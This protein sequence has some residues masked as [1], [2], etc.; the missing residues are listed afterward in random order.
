MQKA[1]VAI[2]DSRFYQHGGVDPK[3]LLRAFLINKI[4]GRI[5]QG[6]STLTQQY[7][8]NVL[9]ES[10]SAQDN[11]Q[12]V[13]DAQEKS[14]G[15]KL[16]E[17]RYAVSLEKE[18]SKDEILNR[19]L[20]IAFF[21]GGQV[22]G[23][24]AAARHYFNV[25]AKKLSL[26]QA[27]MLAG[28]VQNPAAWSPT[29]HPAAALVRRDV[30][31]AR[32]LQ[33]KVIDQAT[34]DA[35][36]KAKLGVKITKA[37]NGCANAGYNA[38]YC[39]YVDL[40]ITQ[41]KSFSSVGATQ[42]ER[43]TALMR[44]GLTIKTTLNPKVQKA[45]WNA[46]SRAVPPKD[47][48]HVAT[49]T[50]TIEPGT[51]KVLSIAQ[52]RYFDGTTRPGRSEV[53]YATDKDYGGSSGFQTGSTFKA[54]TLATWLKQGKSLNASVS[55]AT[56]TAPFSAFKSCEPLDSSQ[57][58]TYANSEG[59]GKGNVSV[60]KAT[61][62]SIN[63]AYVSMEKQLNLCDIRD[64]AESLGVHLASKRPDQCTVAARLTQRLP[65]CVP[66]LTLGSMEIS[67]MTM[68]AAYAAFAAEG[69]YCAP[70][71]VAS[72]TDRN[73]NS[74]AVPG[75]SC[76]QALDKTVDDTVVYGLSRV[77]KPGGTASGV[78]VLPN[79]RPASGKTGTT[80]G[81][82]QTWFVGFTPHF[83]TAVWVGDPLAKAGETLS[84][85]TIDHHRYGTVF[86]AT[87]AAPIWKEIMIKAVDGTP[88]EQFNTPDAKLLQTPK[89]GVPDVA[90][91]TVAAAI[92]ALKGA[93]FTTSV[94][95]GLVPSKYPAGTVAMTSP[96]GNSQ[97]DSGT[98]VAIS[99]SAG[100]GPGGGIPTPTAGP[101][102]GL[103]GVFPTP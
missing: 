51:G 86:G 12:G 82:A 3:G 92:T 100:P 25:D 33:L 50:V 87:I 65:A 11:R 66:S 57:S 1:I 48:S 91:Q 45:S 76:R 20:N 4:T 103:G 81:S 9:I 41:N 58:Y 62:A 80:N 13:Q 69:K 102:G 84:N 35:A 59:S 29:D 73:G 56:G 75:P 96:S 55:A 5:E 74:L 19:Y 40:L 37:R 18:L 71:A 72:I 67:P 63:G 10:A 14:N 49:A 77:L 21:G 43:E 98:E 24:Q 28:M 93:G 97:A 44:G 99:V 8:K 79:G 32:M 16:K 54:F 17:I 36:H 30:V 39:Q 31:L 7:V 94:T 101:G 42:A 38:Y 89:S 26:P 70:M 60:F 47:K 27:A 61:Y 46:T 90:G 22:Y 83:A 78:G 85:R 2:E 68:A 64:T 6:A 53:D 15:R 88:I 23:I 34:Y 52:D 95:P